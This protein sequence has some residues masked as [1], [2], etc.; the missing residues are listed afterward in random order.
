MLSLTDIFSFPELFVFWGIFFVDG[1]LISE[2]R[3]LSF[4]KEKRAGPFIL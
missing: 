4:E 3:L 1:S 2:T